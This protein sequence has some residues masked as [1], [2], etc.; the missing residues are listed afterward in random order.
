M[1]K[2]VKIVGAAEYQTPTLQLTE[3]PAE[4]GFFQSVGKGDIEDPN[5]EEWTNPF[6]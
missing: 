5:E 3:T 1:K 6:A 2:I 4:E